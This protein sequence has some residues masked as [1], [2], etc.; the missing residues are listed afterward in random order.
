MSRTEGSHSGAAS[1]ALVG[2]EAVA[3][4][5]EVVLFSAINLSVD[6]SAETFVDKA[7][8]HNAN[9][10]EMIRRKNCTKNPLVKWTKG[11]VI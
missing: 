10:A 11:Y 3:S 4:S 9:S 7:A 6:S 8:I 2:S 1:D 5:E